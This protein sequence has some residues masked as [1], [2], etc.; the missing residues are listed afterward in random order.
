MQACRAV[1]LIIHDHKHASPTAV[2]CQCNL[3]RSQQIGRPII[4]SPDSPNMA[5]VITNG[6]SNGQSRSGNRPFPQGCRSLGSIPKPGLRASTSPRAHASTSSNVAKPSDAL[7][8]AGTM[9]QRSTAPSRATVEPEQLHS[10]SEL[11]VT[12]S[13]TVPSRILTVPPRVAIDSAWAGS[14]V[15]SCF[16]PQ[17]NRL[18]ARCPSVQMASDTTLPC[19]Q[20]IG[21]QQQVIATASGGA[22]S[23]PSTAPA[24][25]HLP[26]AAMCQDR[27][28][29]VDTIEIAGGVPPT[30]FPLSRQ[31]TTPTRDARACPATIC[32]TNIEPYDSAAGAQQVH[33]NNTPSNSPRLAS[34]LPKNGASLKSAER[35]A[36][37][38]PHRSQAD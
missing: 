37:S 14:N 1:D 20:H 7:G 12:P 33:H 31:H 2:L 3:S 16:S 36:K 11:G 35:A 29:A 34:S 18:P 30:G 21:R 8:N 22:N 24:H 9:K 28:R 25:H 32:I 17:P 10:Q 6:A 13:P 38:R 4:A 27:G 23:A 15:Y 26:T 5:P 19:S